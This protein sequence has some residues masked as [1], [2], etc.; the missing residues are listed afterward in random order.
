MD[1]I[2]PLFA[3][4]SLYQDY[5]DQDCYSGIK[6]CYL[7]GDQALVNCRLL[8]LSG[9]LSREETRQ[10]S[11]GLSIEVPRVT[12]KPTSGVTPSNKL[13]SN[14]SRTTH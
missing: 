1:K 12:M 14:T 6:I 3:I 8:G 9:I 10:Q 5:L 7:A 2:I 13:E 11:L 4:T